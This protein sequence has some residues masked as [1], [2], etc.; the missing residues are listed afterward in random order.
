MIWGPTE[1]RGLRGLAP[2]IREDAGVPWARYLS[3]V[4]R[5]KWLI[6]VLTICGTGLGVASTH[7]LHP[8][9]TATATI[10]IERAPETGGPIR[11]EGLLETTGW[12]DLLRSWVVLDST[13]LR[14]R[15]YLQ[16]D[17]ADSLALAEFRIGGPIHHRESSSWRSATMARHDELQREPGTRVDAGTIGDS[18]GREAGFLWAPSALHAGAGEEASDL[19]VITPAKPPPRSMPTWSRPAGGRQ[20]HESQLTGEDPPGSLILNTI[21]EQFVGSPPT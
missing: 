5:H 16:H 20:L 1:P 19:R 7:F 13:S 18:I 9:Y 17:Q 8:I 14:L 10:F 6:L 2:E 21:T 4:R 11:P 12:V 3:A 15:L